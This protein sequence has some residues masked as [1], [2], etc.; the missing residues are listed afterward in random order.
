[1]RTR[2]LLIG[3]G[4]IL[5][6][7]NAAVAQNVS[8]RVIDQ[9]GNAVEFANVV[10]LNR[11][12][13]SALNGT[14]TDST[15]AFT[16]QSPAALADVCL[17]VSYVGYQTLVQCPVQEQM[18]SITLENTSQNIDEVL[19]TS[20]RKLF[21][22]E[23]N[24]LSA[25]VEGSPLSHLDNATMV[26]N[27]IPFVNSTDS[28][29]E[30]L[31]K[32]EPL[33]YINNR[34]VYDLSE[35][36]NLRASDI[37]DVRV[38]TNPG[39][40]YPAGT[41]SVIRIKLRRLQ[42]DGL[43]GSVYAQAKQA[44]HFNHNG[45]LSLNYRRNAFDVFGM[46]GYNN[47]KQTEKGEDKYKLNALEVE[48]PDEGTQKGLYYYTQTGFN[49]QPTQAHSMGVRYDFN[50]KV[51]DNMEAN[52]NY[53][54]SGS[55]TDTNSYRMTRNTVK[56]PNHR[57]NAY[58]SG[59]LTERFGIV[60]NADY[61]NKNSSNIEDVTDQETQANVH[62]NSTSQALLYSGNL[63]GTLKA[64]GGEFALGTEASLSTHK[65]VYEVQNAPI[66]SSNNLS[67]NGLIA[68]Y[69]NYETLLFQKLQL[70]AGLRYERNNFNYETNGVK[71]DDKSLSY[72]LFTPSISLGFQ[73]QW[74]NVGLSYSRD[75]DK[76]TYSNM[77]N[78]I[79]YTTPTLYTGGNPYLKPT[80]SN[81]IGLQLGLAVLHLMANYEIINNALL[82]NYSQYPGSDAIFIQPINIEKSQKLSIIGVTVL[83]IGPWV[84][85]IQ[86][87]MQKQFL[88]FDGQKYNKPLWFLSVNN[89]VKLPLGMELHANMNSFGFGHGHAMN[90][91]LIPQVRLDAW[92]TKHFL[93]KQLKLNI[94][95]DD[96]LKSGEKWQLVTPNLSISKNSIHDFRCLRIS[97][98][99][100]FNNTRSR[101]TGK[102]SS[103]EI[104][105]M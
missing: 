13:S 51:G 10:L 26:L 12:D 62:A 63:K 67:I 18:G 25:K 42:G 70:Q 3:L 95:V 78:A 86:G 38:L 11:A 37:D 40:E 32:G 46:A 87:G 23:A 8:G 102:D 45:S 79:Q 47:Y 36:Q 99:Y 27:E 64:L 50:D 22:M 20:R 7:I 56:T 35:L 85:Q 96:I 101:Y 97:L 41:R 94:G 4:L 43:S 91:E 76:P 73:W 17:R 48:M 16:L 68:A 69:L 54:T 28:K 75:V 59:Q 34:R 103:E 84:A 65:Q 15:G 61:L 66:A 55:A 49:Y 72:N 31:G 58:Y 19:V 82:L 89:T 105:R 1:M 6:N 92:L 9:Q 83:P 74:L 5:A 81:T 90:I 71:E 88:E 104:K 100:T 60:F 53:Q 77:S 44:Q 39:P 33:V 52:Y 30:V 80:T 24:G 29:L 2:N 93:N 57:V 21:R 14:I 98:N